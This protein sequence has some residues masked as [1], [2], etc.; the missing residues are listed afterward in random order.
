MSALLPP[1]PELDPIETDSVAVICPIAALHCAGR[2]KQSDVEARTHHLMAIAANLFLKHGY[3][4]VSLE[5]IARDAHVAVRTI[6][7]KF[8]GKSGL[9]NAV[10]SAA[11]ERFFEGLSEM[12]TDQRPL[13]TILTDFGVRFLN[14]AMTPHALR[15]QRIVAAEAGNNPDLA[16]AFFKAGPGLTRGILARFF[17]RPE[18][19]VRFRE[20]LSNEVLAAHLTNCLLGDQ[21]ARLLAEPEHELSE[22]ELKAKV[23]FGLDLFLHGTLK[24]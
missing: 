22:A 13:E 12:D 24:H 11:R 14:M 10:I 21:V 5:A 17:S 20:A 3:G 9:F 23:A 19:R 15:I 6:Y 7:V 8:G 2:P 16:R 4:R 18:I 1:M